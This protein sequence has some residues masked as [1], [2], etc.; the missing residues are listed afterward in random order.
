MSMWSWSCQKERRCRWFR[1]ICSWMQCCTVVAQHSICSQNRHQPSDHNAKHFVT[2]V[3]E[4]G[5]SLIIFGEYVALASGGAVLELAMGTCTVTRARAPWTRVL[6]F[7]H[8]Q[9]NMCAC[10]LRSTAWNCRHTALPYAQDMYA[11]SDQSSLQGQHCEA[12]PGP[13]WLASVD[14]SLRRAADRGAQCASC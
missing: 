9:L 11:C 4:V 12:L 6:Q 1:S 3:L 2:L 7:K 10:N 5:A 13:L 8:H 14:R